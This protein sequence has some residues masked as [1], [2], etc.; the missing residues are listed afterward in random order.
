MQR[1]R[2]RQ[3]RPARSGL[4]LLELMIVLIILVGLMAIVG[5]RLLG[6]QKKADIR[7]AQ[8]QIG[9]LSSALKMYVVD[10]KTFPPTE[11]GLEVMLNP[12]EDER[13]ARKWA[14]PYIDGNELPLD[15][16]GNEFEYEYAVS[17]G[18]GS[19]G[20]VDFPRIVS[21]G[22]DGQLGTD[23]DIANRSAEGEASGQDGSA[24]GETSTSEV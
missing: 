24:G 3:R 18:S 2:T 9:N 23:D 6:T 17:E 15:P 20:Q 21:P 4:T 19:Q 8:A 16:W 22:P 7:T 12:P 14:G 11:E 1:L 5:P 10:M 13:L